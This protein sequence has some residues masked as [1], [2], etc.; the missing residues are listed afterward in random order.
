MDSNTTPDSALNVIPF[1]RPD[2]SDGAALHEQVTQRLRQLLVEGQIAPG[3]KLNERELSERLGVSRTPLRE[4]IKRLAAEGLVE[5]LANRG[6]I[7]VQLS[8]ADIE[9]TFEVIAGLEALSGELAA[10]RMTAQELNEVKAL[11]FEMLAAWTRRDLSTYYGLNSRIHKAINLAARNPVLSAT[12]DQVNA[13]LQALRFRSNQNEDKWQQ[14]V[15][16][17]EEMISALTARDGQALRA[18]L[19]RHLQNKREA[20]LAAM[21]VEPQASQ[22]I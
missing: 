13:R 21:P 6:A 5:L 11:H 20:V 22:K 18:V 2:A 1:L 3:A 4:S 9:N 17:H 15:N 16:E 10:V 12:Y 7:A 8:R 19:V 14:A